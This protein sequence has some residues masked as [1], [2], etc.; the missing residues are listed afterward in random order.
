[1]SVFDEMRPHRT[2]DTARYYTE[3]LR[4]LGEAI[5]RGFVEEVPPMLIGKPKAGEKWYRDKE[6][7]T[8]Y[9]S[10]EPD[11]R[12]PYWRPVGTTDLVREGETIQ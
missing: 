3:L 5:S 9:S 12:G 8:I 10:T 4:M 6:D 11:E 1:M 7:G 2:F